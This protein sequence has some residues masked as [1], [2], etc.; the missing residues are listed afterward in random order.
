[1]SWL[2]YASKAGISEPDSLYDYIL[3]NRIGWNFYKVYNEIA[4]HFESKKD[5]RRAD[6]VWR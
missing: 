5:L 4:S 2:K 6:K 3:E 1:M